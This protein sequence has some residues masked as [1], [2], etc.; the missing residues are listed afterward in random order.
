MIRTL[1]VI[2]LLL[3]PYVQGVAAQFDTLALPFRAVT[4]EDG[5]SQGMVNHITQDRYGFMWFATKDGLN[6]Y[7]GYDFTVYRHDPEDSTT[8]RDNFVHA[9]FEDREG[10]LWVGTS[11][12]LDLFDRRTESF[13]HISL[14]PQG[15]DVGYVLN[16]VQ[17]DHGD[18]WIAG[19]AG[20][21][22]LTFGTGGTDKGALPP[23]VVKRYATG[24]TNICRDRDGTL[25]GAQHQL[26]SY[27]IKPRH[28]GF[29][30]LDTLDLEDL[31][32][33]TAGAFPVG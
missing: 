1:R 13:V 2:L 7:D 20:L 33:G 19:S 15:E 16:I 6:R 30:S 9:V 17:D 23:Y 3:V 8:V 21:A 10:R 12:G 26:Y 29:D 11:T 18:I 31:E 4:I 24:H 25:W 5:L 28:D 14:R 22:K 27:R 32:E